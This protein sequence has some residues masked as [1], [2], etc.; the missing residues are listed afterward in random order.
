MDALVNTVRSVFNMCGTSLVS[1]TQ[2]I[3]DYPYLMIGL[4][5]MLIGAGVSF[6]KRLIRV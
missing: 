3:L 1:F 6:L 5:L 4:S 2:T